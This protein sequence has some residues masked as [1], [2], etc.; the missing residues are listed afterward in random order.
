MSAVVPGA[1][2][3]GRGEALRWLG[4]LLVLVGVG[5]R[6]LCAF[7]DMPHWD[8]D[9]LVMSWPM[10]GLGPGGLMALDALVALGAG[11]VF[12]GAALAREQIDR[13]ALVVLAAF[14]GVVAWHG[15][16]AVDRTM[17]DRYVGAAW[18]GALVGAWALGQACRDERVRVG[19][20]AALV[21]VVLAV[22]AKGVIQL[23]VEHPATVADFQRNKAAILAA[24]HWTE[25]SAMARAF[26]RRV[27]QAEPSGWFSLA[28]VFGSLAAGAAVVLG[29]L[30]AG[31]ARREGAWAA[32]GALVL[33]GGCAVMAVLSGSKGTMA[34]LV[35]GSAAAAVA[36][37][38]RG[39]RGGRL[40]VLALVCIAA[41]IAAV[42]ARGVVGER[43]GELSLLFRS[44][45]WQGAARMVGEHPLVGV[46][47]G[48][49]QAAFMV[50]KPALCPEDVRSAHN[51]LVDWVATLGV[52]GAA[53]GALVLAWL[54]RAVAAVAN[55]REAGPGWTGEM[56]PVLRLALGAGAAC[57]LIAAWVDAGGAT[58]L[59]AG[60]RIATLSACLVG[61][62]VVVR[63]GGR[64]AL[65]PALALGALT[66]LVQ[67]QIEV[68]GTWPTSAGLAMALLGAAA[69]GG[70]GEERAR[71][72]KAWAWGAA[73]VCG[74]GAAGLLVMGTG[75]ALR[76]ERALGE[77]A[78]AVAPV[79][80]ARAL[81][82][83]RAAARLAV[84]LGRPVGSDRASLETAARELAV[85]RMAAAAAGLERAWAAA[86]D[87]WR[88]GRELSR[89][90]GA[91]AKAP[92]APADAQA[93]SVASADRAAGL[94]S[95]RSGA[96]VWAAM[97]RLGMTAPD[98]AGA[99]RWLAVGRERDPY[100]PSLAML[101]ASVAAEDG[102]MGEA[103]ER[104]RAALAV[105]ELARL[106][107]V[108][109]G[110]SAGQVAQLRAWAGEP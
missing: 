19:V 1:R 38:W 68:T 16:V 91:L 11:L 96:A 104:A 72:S 31:V 10:V 53:G 98:R 46:G 99:E 80:E 106:D 93:R 55:D 2:A 77:A 8:V 90:L 95:G 75:P 13:A 73:G 5:T 108:G 105:N 39:A 57:T 84:E 51:M 33:A 101:W 4:A 65:R 88:T 89:V 70:G 14:A 40:G 81:P 43:V 21:G 47:P 82:P 67:A 25:D 92:G 56:R 12:V 42:V 23:L 85:Q 7:T 9:P 44:M 26:E 74:A 34:T 103:R 27:M 97:V 50:A 94:G 61:G 32:R 35:L 52:A 22:C 60:A 45:Y 63:A 78:G 29:S 110:L 37:R 62:L 100:N 76:W 15:W 83:D 18:W 69:P 30:G 41:P 66:V 109:R 87:D 86:P 17:E 59:D 64:A 102:R 24:H 20:G 54:V 58:P 71:G 6:A 107:P 48:G 28:N 36:L 3:D 79:A 49:F